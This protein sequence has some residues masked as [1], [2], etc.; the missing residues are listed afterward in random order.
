MDLKLAN[1][2]VAFY[3]SMLDQTDL[4]VSNSSLIFT[5][6]YDTKFAASPLSVNKNESKVE[7]AY[8][9]EEM[10][11]R[12]LSLDWLPN[13]KHDDCDSNVFR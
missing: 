6:K 12:S 8:N 1:Q 2:S 7:V 10:E 9:L 4:S 13:Y 3:A 11:I 5:N